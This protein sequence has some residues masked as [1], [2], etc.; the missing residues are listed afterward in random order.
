MIA[1]APLVPDSPTYPK[2]ESGEVGGPRA[3]NASCTKGLNL[4]T[5]GSSG[6]SCTDRI[7]RLAIEMGARL[8][9]VTATIFANPPQSALE[10]K[11]METKNILLPAPE[12]WVPTIFRRVGLREDTSLPAARRLLLADMSGARTHGLARLPSYWRQLNHGGIN[13]R[14]NITHGWHGTVLVFDADLGFGQIVR[15]YA[16]ALA[17][18]AL[19]AGRPFVR[20]SSATPRIWA[21]SARIYSRWRI[22]AEVA[23]LS[24]VTHL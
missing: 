23:F 24:Q 20:S 9:D 3:T 2:P 16:F 15:P 10:R 17:L 18:G 13:P 8:E 19:D 21:R 6:L 11:T 7:P 22:R 14:P 1:T 4:G 5:V 12:A